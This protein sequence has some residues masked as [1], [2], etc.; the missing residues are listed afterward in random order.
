MKKQWKFI[1]FQRELM[2]ILRRE[3]CKKTSRQQKAPPAPRCFYT[4]IL[5]QSCWN[6]HKSQAKTPA[7]GQ[8]GSAIIIQRKLE[9]STAIILPT[10]HPVL[11]RQR[12]S[13]GER[14]L[15]HFVGGIHGPKSLL[16][17]PYPAIPPYV[18]RTS[19]PGIT[20]DRV[21]IIVSK[22]L[23]LLKLYKMVQHKIYKAS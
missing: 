6:V 17:S 18:L 9:D 23:K 10:G 21:W 12:Y 1:T 15:P 22:F 20:D 5:I 16:F 8:P 11:G 14:L 19:H 7:C 13:H 2:R 4:R 3:S